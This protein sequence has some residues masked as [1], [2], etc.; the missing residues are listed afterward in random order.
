MAFP[1]L[2]KILNTYKGA[3]V[4]VLPI[5]GDFFVAWKLINLVASVS[6]R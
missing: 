2:A 5:I 1:L 4:T 6:E 3:N